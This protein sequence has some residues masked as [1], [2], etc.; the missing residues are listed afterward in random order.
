M[1]PS[2]SST[3]LDPF[4]SRCL[5]HSIQENFPL[6]SI[7]VFHHT[8]LAFVTPLI[9]LSQSRHQATS[10][11]LN[12]QIL[13]LSSQTPIPTHTPKPINNNNNLSIQHTS[14]MPSQQYN[15]YRIIGTN[16]PHLP[17]PGQPE[18][19]T[20][21]ISTEDSLTQAYIALTESYCDC[22]RQLEP[23]VIGWSRPRHTIGM[24]ERGGCSLR[25]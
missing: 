18:F 4:P 7:S 13:I 12:P 6:L 17:L 16:P 24:A 25:R 11:Y 21:L 1:K 20:S 5:S 14:T 3:L 19:V 9:L 23:L 10:P 2:I 22:E 8:N 15:I